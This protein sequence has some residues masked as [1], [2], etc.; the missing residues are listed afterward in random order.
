MSLLQFKRTTK[1]LND[2]ITEVLESSEPLLLDYTGKGLYTTE[3]P[4][5]LAV[6]NV[7]GTDTTNVN[8]APVFKAFK[9]MIPYFNEDYFLK[10]GYEVVRY[11]IVDVKAKN[12]K[13][14]YDSTPIYYQNEDKV[15]FLEEM[16]AVFPRRENGQN[17]I[18][19]YSTYRYDKENNFD[20]FK[21]IN[22]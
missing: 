3:T 20:W 18:Y 17:R 5:Y 1:S 16:S 6:G 9:N 11:A 15:L 4:V 22:S 8:D 14:D 19:K 13:V 2:I 12:L 10:N 7:K 21:T